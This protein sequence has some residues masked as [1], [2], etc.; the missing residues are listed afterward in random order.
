MTSA[1]S[2]PSQNFYCVHVYDDKNCKTGCLLYHVCVHNDYA[3]DLLFLCLSQMCW[4][5]V[6]SDSTLFC[7]GAPQNNLKMHLAF[8]FTP[9][10][11]S[12]ISGQHAALTSSSCTTSHHI[13][14][15]AIT[16]RT[17][18]FTFVL[19][20]STIPEVKIPLHFMLL[21]SLL[22]PQITS[23]YEIIFISSPSNHL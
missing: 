1:H 12:I 5:Q 2:N 20:W 6:K 13:Q 10:I 21:K 17:S 18:F 11:N 9:S 16:D 22:T 7:V 19:N 14:S 3:F 23:F 8:A 15:V 4:R